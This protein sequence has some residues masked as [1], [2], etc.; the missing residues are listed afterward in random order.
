MANLIILQYMYSCVIY[1]TQRA[2]FVSPS[3]SFL[4]YPSLS[5]SLTLF[6]PLF[7]T[8]SLQEEK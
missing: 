4:K 3:I 1:K 8:I 6:L 2:G 5:Q 7:L